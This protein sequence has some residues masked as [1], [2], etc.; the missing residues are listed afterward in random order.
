MTP[1]ELFDVVGP[2]VAEHVDMLRTAIVKTANE[3]LVALCAY[4]SAARGEYRE[5][6]SG[7]DLAIVLRMVP[8][9]LLLELGNPLH[10]ARNGAR[11]Q[12]I[13]LVEREL[14]RT[15]DVFPLFYADIQRHHVTLWGK[16]PF[17]NLHID[18]T[19]IR[20]RTEQELRELQMRLRRAVIDTLGTKR[21]LAGVIM[22]KVK[23]ARLPLHALLELR[24]L[25]CSDQLPAVLERACELYGVGCST[26]RHSNEAPDQALGALMQ[27]FDRAIEDVDRLETT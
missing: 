2:R 10:V 1:E 16:S 26:L 7:L 22:R 8:A 19:H 23:Q 24:G 3:D 27:L 21:L 9:P 14:A 25:S 18:R 5:G 6:E 12:S 11:V 15:T 4:G 17:G 13:L 20:L